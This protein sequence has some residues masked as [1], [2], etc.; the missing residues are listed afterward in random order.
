MI[1]TNRKSSSTNSRSL[2]NVKKDFDHNSD[3][4]VGD[5]F[6]LGDEERE[7]DKSPLENRNNIGNDNNNY[8]NNNNNNNNSNNENNEIRAERRR[9]SEESF[10]KKI[11]SPLYRN[12]LN[13]GYGYDNYN[14]S[15]NNYNNNNNT[16]NFYN[17]NNNINNNSSMNMSNVNN[18]T[19]T[20]NKLIDKIDI[21]KYARDNAD[22]ATKS[23]AHH[24][25]LKDLRKRRNSILHALS[26]LQP[27]LLSCVRWFRRRNQYI[28]CV[29]IQSLIRGY[30]I[31]RDTFHLVHFLRFRKA[32]R[33][34]ACL[35]LRNWAR[36]RA[37]AVY[38]KREYNK[39]V[40]LRRSMM[41]YMTL[42]MIQEIGI[43]PSSNRYVHTYVLAS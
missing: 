35:L 37:E 2:I 26:T 7:R 40:V 32:L 21:R 28:A 19:Y 43:S 38:T 18:V 27:F 20:H 29:I 17:S 5:L 16:S 12:F 6:R 9:S 23:I 41:A 25:Y 34:L 42:P 15:D 36:R 22:S 3:F 24:Y 11:P 30:F 31:R 10:N 4:F 13:S 8:S 33:M 39:S 1:G 14:L